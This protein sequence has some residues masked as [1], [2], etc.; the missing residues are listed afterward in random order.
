MSISLE[1]AIENFQESCKSFA[2]NYMKHHDNMPMMVVFLTQNEKNEFVTILSPQLGIIHQEEEKEIF[3]HAV[4]EAIKA[5]KPIAI[6]M[7]CE[8]WVVKH[9][10]DEGPI[11]LSIPPSQQP[12]KEEVILVQIETHRNAYITMYDIIRTTSGNIEL[13]LDEKLSNSKLDKENTEGMF[14]NLLKDN[15]DNFYKSIEESLNKFQ[16]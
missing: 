12:S 14:S 1:K 3:L 9:S 4:K 16:N 7:I 13:E 8:A 2:V 10:K 11:D 5:V 15:Y 6:A